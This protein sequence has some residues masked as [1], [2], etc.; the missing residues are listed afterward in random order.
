LAI[1]GWLE[2]ILFTFSVHADIEFCIVGTTSLS[3]S[4]SP[5]GKK[6]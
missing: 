2:E 6:Y 3:W 1:G 5:C 4:I